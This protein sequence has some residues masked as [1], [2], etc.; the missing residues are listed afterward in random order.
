M[1]NSVKKFKPSTEILQFGRDPNKQYGF[2]N[3]PIYRGS[4]IIY[5][6]VSDIEN[7]NARYDY[8]TAGSPTIE[9]LESAWTHLTGAA[10]TVLSPSG[11]GAIALALLTTTKSGDHLL[12]PDSAYRPSRNFCLNTLAKFGVETTYY[13]PLIGSDI[14]GLIKSNTSTIFLEAPGSQT[15]EVQDI[16]AIVSVA[17]K[18]N[19]KTILDNTWATPIFFQAHKHGI[20]LSLEA[21]TKYLSGHSDLLMGLISAN[22]ETWPDLRKMYSSMAMLPGP[23]DC[24]LAL[25]GLRTMHLRLKEAERKGIEMEKWLKNRPEVLRVLHPAFPECPGHE[26]WKRDFTGSSGLFSIVLDPKFNKSNLANMLDHMSLFSMGFSWGG[27]E[28]LIIPFDCTEYRTATEWNPGGLTLRLQ[29]G[30]EDIEDLKCDLIE[31]FERLNQVI[32]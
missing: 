23:E 28:S 19:I 3:G 32:C 16:P 25:R 4:T 30:L 13:N 18:H 9:N 12:M 6:S 5:N 7:R 24:F 27:Y 8:G 1:N 26:Y 29:I 15:F 31:G 22:Q 17:K 14:E 2:V 11:L 20:D 10:G 21:G